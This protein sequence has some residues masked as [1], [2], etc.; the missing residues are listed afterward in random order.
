MRKGER[1]QKSWLVA[2]DPDSAVLRECE[3]VSLGLGGPGLAD[4]APPSKARKATSGVS[5][6]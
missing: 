2:H 1:I 4:S 6:V 5:Q 3:G